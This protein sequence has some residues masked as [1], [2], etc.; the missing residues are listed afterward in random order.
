MAGW[1]IPTWQ[2]G[3]GAVLGSIPRI[4]KYFK[5]K[6]RINEVKKIDG[7]VS[8]GDD[9]SVNNILH[10]ITDKENKRTGANS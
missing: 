7:A 3:A 1:K 10:K 9:K 4:I 6:G 8:S 5:D 2:E